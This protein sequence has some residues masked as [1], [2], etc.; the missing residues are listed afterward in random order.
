MEGVEGASGQ[1]LDASDAPKWGRFHERK[2]GTR[3]VAR[4]PRSLEKAWLLSSI[5]Q[6]YL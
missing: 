4:T 2:V 1:A 3:R 5:A 6:E